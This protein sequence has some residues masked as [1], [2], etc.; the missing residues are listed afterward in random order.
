MSLEEDVMQGVVVQGVQIAIGVFEGRA[1]HVCLAE[2]EEGGVEL[3]ESF[4]QMTVLLG[5]HQHHLTP[6][7]AYPQF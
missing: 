4:R 2:F 7:D 5:T 3:L 6:T 1:R